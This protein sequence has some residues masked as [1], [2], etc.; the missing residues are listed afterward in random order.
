M[1][2]LSQH[3]VARTVTAC[4]TDDG[5]VIIRD[6]FIFLKILKE[7]C[8]QKGGLVVLAVCYEI[9]IENFSYPIVM[10]DI[11]TSVPTWNYPSF[12]VMELF[13]ALLFDFVLPLCAPER[14]EIMPSVKQDLG[15][16]RLQF[17][18][19]WPF[20]AHDK[21]N[22][23]LHI[24]G[25]GICSSQFSIIQPLHAHELSEIMTYMQLHL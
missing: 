16:C 11:D 15:S 10:L 3:C 8:T 5:R 25:P 21:R 14:S 24:R 17:D 2:W 23:D 6:V 7:T 9:K 4:R 20:N 22:D 13:L 1:Y 19:I 18:F 12:P